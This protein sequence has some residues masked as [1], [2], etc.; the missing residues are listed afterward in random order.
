[1]YGCIYIHTC[2]LQE[3]LKFCVIANV[4]DF[5]LGFWR[6]KAYKTGS[7]AIGGESVEGILRNFVR[8]DS[9]VTV[10]YN[11]STFMMSLHLTVMCRINKADIPI[12]LVTIKS[13]STSD[14]DVE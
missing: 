13:D 8:G 7:K 5:Y 14:F 12:E 11:S 4:L 6:E 9:V 2:I 10:D 1:V 3:L